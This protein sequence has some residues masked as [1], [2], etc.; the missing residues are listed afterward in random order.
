MKNSTLEL[1]RLKI[2]HIAR[3]GVGG[4]ANKHAHE[5]KAYK[6]PTPEGMY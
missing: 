3:A 2:S 5:E 4:P 6:T 1:N